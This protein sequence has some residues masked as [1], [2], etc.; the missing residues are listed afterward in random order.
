MIAK[1]A[2]DCLTGNNVKML[3]V[4]YIKRSFDKIKCVSNPLNADVDDL[5]FYCY[6]RLITIL[7]I[8]WINDNIV[9]SLNNSLIVGVYMN[10]I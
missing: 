3:K 9:K 7:K 10:W 1:W 5:P 2:I 8:Y 4:G 6:Q